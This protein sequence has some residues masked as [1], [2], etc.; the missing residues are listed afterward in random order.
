M[1]PRCKLNRSKKAFISDALVDIWSYIMFVLIVIVFA[2]IYKYAS[3]EKT[4]ALENIYDVTYGN[5]LAQVYLRTPVVVGNAQLTMAELLS[6]YDY[7]QTLEPDEGKLPEGLFAD[8]F[9]WN[10][11]LTGQRDASSDFFFGKETDLWRGIK[12]ITDDFVRKNFNSDKC[13]L[14]GIKANGFEYSKMNDDVTCKIFR[15]FTP[16]KV[17]EIDLGP[18][19]LKV[20]GVND[21][22]KD[23]YLTYLPSIDP[24]KKPIEI[25]SIYDVSKLVPLDSREGDTIYRQSMMEF[26]RTH[27]LLSQCRQG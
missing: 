14:F 22:P 9:D 25:Y 21:V 20:V 5:Y 1:K 4:Q 12:T 11:D 19:K 2:I 23:S 6:M 7:N 18:F 26:C 13:Y 16:W 8:L 3:S 10:V 15:G 24:R 27:P 17:S